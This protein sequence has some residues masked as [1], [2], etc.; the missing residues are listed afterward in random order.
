MLDYSPPEKYIVTKFEL[1]KG[2]GV[3]I[4]EQNLTGDF[5]HVLLFN[6]PY[7]VV[8]LKECGS[9]QVNIGLAPP[10]ET[11]IPTEDWYTYDCD[12]EGVIMLGNNSGIVE[13]LAN[14]TTN[15]SYTACYMGD[16]EPG[17]MQFTRLTLLAVG[18]LNINK[19][20]ADERWGIIL[21][22]PNTRASVTLTRTLSTDPLEL[23][24][25]G[26]R[27]FQT[28]LTVDSP[29]AFEKETIWG[30]EILSDG[31]FLGSL[32]VHLSDG[33]RY[34]NYP[35]LEKEDAMNNFGL[36]TVTGTIENFSLLTEVPVRYA[37]EEPDK[38]GPGWIA[39]ICICCVV[40]VG[41]I[42]VAIFCVCRK[43]KKDNG[44]HDAENPNPSAEPKAHEALPQDS[45]TKPSVSVDPSEVNPNDTPGEPTNAPSGVV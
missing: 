43:G 32:G 28:N 44:E 29:H 4:A 39:M 15:I 13:I 23:L 8:I 38:L 7:G 45:A 35:D 3:G 10:N 9:C 17:V 6:A 27:E 31:E 21:T 25:H 2:T 16:A 34:R 11:D 5:S 12:H 42:G 40:V 30:L 33:D 37:L 20:T 26:V 41:G 36:W 24:G 1:A 19:V 22:D 18:D 14:E